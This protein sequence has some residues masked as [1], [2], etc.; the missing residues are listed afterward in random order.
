M[1]VEDLSKECS[2]QRGT[3]TRAEVYRRVTFALGLRVMTLGTENRTML[4]DL[5]EMLTNS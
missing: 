2:V 3:E 5:P 4:I 1:A